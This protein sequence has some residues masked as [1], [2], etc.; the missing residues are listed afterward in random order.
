[1][2]HDLLLPS[3]SSLLPCMHIPSN[4][5][6]DFGSW[7]PV[8]SSPELAAPMSSDLLEAGVHAHNL[9]VGWLDWDLPATL[10]DLEP[11]LAPP[12]PAKTESSLPQTL[13]PESPS[14]VAFAADLEFAMPLLSPQTCTTHYDFDRGL[15]DDIS[16]LS[17][18]ADVNCLLGADIVD[19]NDVAETAKRELF[20]CFQASRDADPP[21]LSSFSRSSAANTS[22]MERLRKRQRG[23]EQK[24]RKKKRVRAR[25]P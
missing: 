10:V 1:M 25:L 2:R 8:C 15:L 5:D 3:T 21:Q 11:S 14:C 18:V 7:A 6:G 12:T 17:S 22:G 16:A 13:S 23:Y 9:A 19:E 24:Y 4:T 20:I